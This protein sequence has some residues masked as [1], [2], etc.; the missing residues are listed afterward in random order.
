MTTSPS[1]GPPP[2]YYPQDAYYAPG[3]SAPVDAPPPP[4][5]HRGARTVV[6]VLAVLGVVALVGVVGVGAR[7]WA[8]SRPL[9]TVSG[10][11]SAHPRQLVAGHCVQT[12]PPDGTVRR[13]TLVPCDRPH[14]AEV[15]A[16]HR[17][18]D[19]PWPGDAQVRREAEAACEMDSAQQQAGVQP[20]V[21]APT[22]ASWRQGDRTSLCLAWLPGLR[23]SWTEGDVR[24]P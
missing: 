5:G 22:E 9:G 19:G 3:W 16:T 1:G 4:R 20:V 15:L 23:G 10:D 6:R 8:D 11:V 24:L 12:L 14:E 17:H 7:T 21:W 13:T 2:G 18:A